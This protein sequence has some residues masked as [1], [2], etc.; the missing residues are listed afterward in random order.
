MVDWADI[1]PVETRYSLRYG[2]AVLAARN[3]TRASSGTIPEQMIPNRSDL[4]ALFPSW[5]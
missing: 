4:F 3:G 2:C 1:Q 5:R